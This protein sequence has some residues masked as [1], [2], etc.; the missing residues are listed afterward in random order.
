MMTFNT[1]LLNDQMIN[2]I[3]YLKLFNRTCYMIYPFNGSTFYNDRPLQVLI[4]RSAV[5][6]HLLWLLFV[7]NVIL[8]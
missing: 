8:D 4:N 6:L 7:N 5:R 1:V 3:K 2:V